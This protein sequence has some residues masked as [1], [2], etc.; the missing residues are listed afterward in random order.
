MAWSGNLSTT[1]SRLSHLSSILYPQVD[2]DVRLRELSAIAKF[3]VLALGG[4]DVRFEVSPS[5][6]RES[7]FRRVSAHSRATGLLYS[8]SILQPLLDVYR[9][10]VSQHRLYPLATRY[11]TDQVW[12]KL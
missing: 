4:S 2:S 11:L 8:R 3:D 7:L 5:D 12:R 9:F 6:H 1:I 10:G